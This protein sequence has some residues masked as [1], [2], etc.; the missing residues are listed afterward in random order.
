MVII[1]E[2]DAFFRE[3]TMLSPKRLKEYIGFNE[4]EVRELCMA[5]NMD[6]DE[7]CTWYDGYSFSGN[8]HVFGPNSVV[9]AMLDGNCENYCS[10]IQFTVHIHHYE[11]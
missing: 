6:Y 2:W 9:Q 7:V 8:G 11:F 3:Y 1:D 4:D 5:Y 10:G